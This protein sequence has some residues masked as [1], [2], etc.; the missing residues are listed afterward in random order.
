[1]ILPRRADHKDLDMGKYMVNVDDVTGAMRPA[2]WFC[3]SAESK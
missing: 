2:E 3:A 1:M